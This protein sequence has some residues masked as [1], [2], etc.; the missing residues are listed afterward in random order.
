MKNKVKVNIYVKPEKGRKDSFWFDGHV[1]SV[2]DGET[3]ID[4]VSSGEIGVTFNPDEDL[5]KNKKA[6]KEAKKRGYTDRKLNNIMNS[7]DGWS[8]NNWF[9]YIIEKK[10]QR[11]SDNINWAD[12]TDINFDDAIKR[13]KNLLKVK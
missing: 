8:N 13:A 7:H 12:S 6:V 3:T 11:K 9:G 10:G 5:F 4:I 1:A 2:T